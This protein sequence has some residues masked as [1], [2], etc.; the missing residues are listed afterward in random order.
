MTEPLTLKGH[1]ALPDIEAL[2]FDWRALRKVLKKLQRIWSESRE[3]DAQ[4][5]A[6]EREV[7]DLERRAAGEMVDGILSG[8]E[9]HGAADALPAAREKLESLR[10]RSQAYGQALERMHREI[11]ACAEKHAEEYIADVRAKA[12]EQL[13]E[14]EAAVAH[15]QQLVAGLHLLGSLSEWLERPQKSFSY[16]QPDGQPFAAI[17]EEAR[18]SKALPQEMRPETMVIAHPGHT[19]PRG[20]VADWLAPAL[21]R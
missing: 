6:A 12:T 17:L 7:Q 15:L 4:F 8:Q 13:S 20:P 3:I 18:S 10:E 16:G 21:E 19:A 11:A 9:V 14:V 5:V 1:R 2:G